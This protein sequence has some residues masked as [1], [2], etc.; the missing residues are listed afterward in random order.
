M[1]QK[2]KTLPVRDIFPLSWCSAVLI[3]QSQCKKSGQQDGDG[4]GE[5][6]PQG[7]DPDGQTELPKGDVSK[8]AFPCVSVKIKR[9]AVPCDIFADQGVQHK[10]STEMRLQQGCM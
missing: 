5:A 7:G 8:R 3:Y 9:R 10:A 2:H 4:V 1:C 6:S